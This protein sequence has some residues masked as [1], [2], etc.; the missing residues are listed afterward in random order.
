MEQLSI[1]ARPN[2]FIE[3][4]TEQVASEHFLDDILLS[5]PLHHQLLQLQPGPSW[6]SFS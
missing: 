4:V 5:P 1:L 6:R 3:N 2:I